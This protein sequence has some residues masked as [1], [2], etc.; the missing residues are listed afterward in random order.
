MCK[1]SI[2]TRTNFQSIRETLAK[3]SAVSRS[4]MA[5]FCVLR[6][7]KLFFCAYFLVAWPASFCFGVLFRQCLN[8]K[9]FFMT[10]IEV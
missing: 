10:K 7:E 4:E 8:R 6:G 2:A 5:F 9:R 3:H 1:P